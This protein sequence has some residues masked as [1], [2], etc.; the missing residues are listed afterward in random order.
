M[1]ATAIPIVIIAYFTG[2]LIKII[3][4]TLYLDEN[5][6]M[7]LICGFC[8]VIIS[9][10][11]YRISF[12]NENT[13]WFCC[14]TYLYYKQQSHGKELSV[15]RYSTLALESQFHL[16]TWVKRTSFKLSFKDS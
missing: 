12:Y 3:I 16:E 6:S 11:S 10:E 5:V 4:C 1:I 8:Y 14:F 13:R 7:V 9:F 15:P 2:L